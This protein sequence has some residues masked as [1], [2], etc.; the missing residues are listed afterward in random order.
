MKY[1]GKQRRI[2]YRHPIKVPIQLQVE[3]SKKT[4]EP[5]TKDVSLGGL[6]FH[7]PKKLSKGFQVRIQIPVGQK[8][9]DV[10]AKIVYS[11]ETKK[12]A[13]YRV[14]VKFTDFP[15]AFK[16]R[17]AE[18]ILRI[19]EFQKKISRELGSELSEEEAAAR[20]IAEYAQK[21]PS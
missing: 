1:I 5:T 12:P 3:H 2:F 13:D 11:R 17:L 4:L 9:F 10:N 16:A 15:S 14:G 8:K 18:E 7:W 21:F 20:W 6:S 19:H